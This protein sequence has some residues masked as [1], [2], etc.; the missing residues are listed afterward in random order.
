METEASRRAGRFHE[1]GFRVTCAERRRPDEV[2][3]IDVQYIDERSPFARPRPA[4][5][6]REPGGRRR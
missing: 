3:E 5:R 2:L 4:C 1:A 6:E